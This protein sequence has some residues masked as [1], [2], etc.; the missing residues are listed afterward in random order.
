VKDIPNTRSSEITI[1]RRRYLTTNSFPSDIRRAIRHNP[2][3]RTA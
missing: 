2:A 3:T 1:S